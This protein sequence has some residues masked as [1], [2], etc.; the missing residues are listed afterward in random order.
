MNDL[1]TSL[2]KGYKP[3]NPFKTFWRAVLMVKFLSEN[4][5][6]HATRDMS[7]F[8]RSISKILIEYIIR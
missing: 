6:I 1:K 8:Y 7:I 5:L 4:A 3:M 2:T